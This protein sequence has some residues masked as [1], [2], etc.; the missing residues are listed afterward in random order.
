MRELIFSFIILFWVGPARATVCP[1]GDDANFE[2]KTKAGPVISVCGFEDREIKSP[3]GKRPFT[4]FSIYYTSTK[5]TQP[6]KIFSSEMSD[7]YWIQP[8]GESSL[9]IEELWFFANK[10]QGALARQVTCSAETC[11]VSGARCIFKIKANSYPKALAKFEAEK[12]KGKFDEDG[13][14]LLDQIFA[15]ALTGDAKALQFYE[16]APPDG[17]DAAMAEAFQTNHKKLGEIKELK[18]R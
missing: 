7:T 10:P 13:E 15:Q 12:K 1:S 4:E 5:V 17:L 3:K 18:C 2:F 16:K 6:E 11:T 9:E 8:K 14:E